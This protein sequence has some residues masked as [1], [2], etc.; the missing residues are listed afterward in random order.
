MSAAASR[1]AP[2]SLEEFPEGVRLTA[3]VV[4]AN[5]KPAVTIAEMAK[6]IGLATTP[7]F[8]IVAENRWPKQ[9]DADKR[10]QI[11]DAIQ[12]LLAERGATAEQLADLWKPVTTRRRDLPKAGAY[13]TSPTQRSETRRQRQEIADML[14][15]KCSL[16]LEARRHFELFLNPFD[17]EVGSDSQLY[18]NGEM[19]YI[20]EAM[21]QTANHSS[22]VGVCGESGAG[23]ST[24][25]AD[26]MDRIEREKLKLVVV[27]PTVVATHNG[28]EV[29]LSG[30]DI[31]TAIILQMDPLARVKVDTQRRRKQAKDLI[32]QSVLSGNKHLLLLEE[33]HKL[34]K[35]SLKSLKVL[36]EE[37]RAGRGPSLGILLLAQPELRT[38]LQGENAYD[39]RE[40]SQRLE[41]LDLRPLMGASLNEYLKHRCDAA[42]KELAR[43]ID[44]DGIDALRERLVLKKSGGLKPQYV[45]LSYPL[46]I[47][48]FMTA[49]LNKAAEIGAPKVTANIVMAV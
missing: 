24:L 37:M 45:S 14:L 18:L 47:N 36:H 23:K 21:W 17:G 43:F 1:P 3:S 28:K 32:T 33:A 41:I 12:A 35:D 29:R 8:N 6:A 30:Q 31:L 49:A 10:S 25:L 48:N 26:L 2:V 42:G 15:S 46:A 16:S 19:A 7:T 9:A 27:K 4:A 34:P 11:R 13:E 20:R 40:V 22:F 44:V 38:K 5:L 39:V